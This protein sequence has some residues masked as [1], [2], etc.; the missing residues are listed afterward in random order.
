MCALAAELLAQ[1]GAH[2]AI[3]ADQIIEMASH[4][5]MRSMCAMSAEVPAQIGAEN[6]ICA[7][8]II[9]MASSSYLRSI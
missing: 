4:S 7:N 9:K 8:H 5:Y 3:C 1:I 2:N 6:A